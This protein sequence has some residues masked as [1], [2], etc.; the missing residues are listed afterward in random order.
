M[1]TTPL[2]VGALRNYL[3]EIVKEMP[4]WDGKVSVIQVTDA[5]DRTI[6]V[7]ALVSARTSPEAWDLR[8]DVREKLISWVRDNH[9]DSLPQV[10]STAV[11]QDRGTVGG[12]VGE[13]E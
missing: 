8:C 10:R 13:E 7:R 5:T 12:I 9:P 4:L 2:P 1:P 6:E 3:Q 11:P